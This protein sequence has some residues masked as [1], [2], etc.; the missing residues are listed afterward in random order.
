MV[1]LYVYSICLHVPKG[2]DVE[3]VLRCA[4][5]SCLG[6]FTCLQSIPA[7]GIMSSAYR[8]RGREGDH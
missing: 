1:E 4:C 6:L 8:V 2:T 5:V 7:L 3:E